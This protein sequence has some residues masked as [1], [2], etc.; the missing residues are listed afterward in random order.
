MTVELI[1]PDIHS[2]IN[3]LETSFDIFKYLR[4]AAERYG[5]KYFSVLAMPGDMSGGFKS[6]SIIN[7]WPP[8]LITAY[9]RLDLINI[10][11]R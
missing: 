7:N 5:L 3:E 9:D 10:T 6:H 8:E 4:K 1:R 2:D 11:A